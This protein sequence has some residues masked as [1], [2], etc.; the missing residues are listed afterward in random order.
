MGKA[1]GLAGQMRYAALL[2]RDR[3]MVKELPVVADTETKLTQ[4]NA[5]ARRELDGLAKLTGDQ[6]VFSKEACTEM[7]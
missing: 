2:G 6:R 7:G 1:D 3:T 5:D 4:T